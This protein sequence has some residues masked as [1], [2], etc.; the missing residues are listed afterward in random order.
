MQ[1]EALEGKLDGLVIAVWGCDE[2]GAQYIAFQSGT[3][4]ES[5]G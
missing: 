1:T 2:S 5:G 4:F 3:H